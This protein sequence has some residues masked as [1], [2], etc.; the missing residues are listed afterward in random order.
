QTESKLVAVN[1]TDGKLAWESTSASQGGGP[2]GQGGEGGRGRGMGG[3]D[4][5]AATPIVDGQTIIIAGRG[6]K[7]VK[8]EKDGDKF[9]EKE[10]WNNPDKSVQFNTPALRAGMLY[11]LTANNELFCL[12]AG[13]GT[14]AWSSPFPGSGAAGTPR[15]AAERFAT[16]QTVFGQPAP[17]GQAEPDRPRGPGG[18]GGP[19]GRRGGGMG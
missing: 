12:N 8:L 13:D 3:R 11:G 10:L 7:A 19:G 15:A 5:K 17:G 4:Y 6:V 16:A 14:L 1:A 2:G 9:V 18:P